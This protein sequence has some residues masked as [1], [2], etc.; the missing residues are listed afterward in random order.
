M[1]LTTNLPF[2]EWT[3]VSQCAALQGAVGPYH[4]LW[5]HPENRHRVLQVLSHAG[6]TAEISPAV[7]KGE[8]AKTDTRLE[9]SLKTHCFSR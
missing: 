5:T 4:Q 8:I 6:K 3:Q 7:P 9:A 2:S 1:I